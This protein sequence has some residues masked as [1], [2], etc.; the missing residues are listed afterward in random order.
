MAN[1]R[2]HER[3][4]LP[5]EVR[6]ESLSG[7]YVARLSDVSPGGCFVETLAQV[8]VG[9]RIRFEIKLPTGRWLPLCGEVVYF[10]AT[11]GFGVR[12]TDLTELDHQ[13]LA[14]LI[15]YGRES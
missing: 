8:S 13:M 3:T 1:R 5:L 10:Q 4:S 11:L 15:E 9:E 6:L 7:R 2:Q 12:F 14:I